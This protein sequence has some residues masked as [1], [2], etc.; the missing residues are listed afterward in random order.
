[1]DYNGFNQFYFIFKLSRSTISFTFPEIFS[2]HVLYNASFSQLYQFNRQTQKPNHSI[3]HRCKNLFFSA[4]AL[5]NTCA[6]I[7]LRAD[8]SAADFFFLGKSPC[9]LKKNSDEQTQVL[10]QVFRE[11]QVL[12]QVFRETQVL[13]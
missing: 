7:F 9:L 6:L 12:P 2:P 5:K 10:P 13:P 1:M 4:T 11:T 3:L 8:F